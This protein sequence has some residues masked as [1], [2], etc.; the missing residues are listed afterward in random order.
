[1]VFRT[2]FL[3]GWPPEFFSDLWYKPSFFFRVETQKKKSG[4]Q[5]LKFYQG[6]KLN[7]PFLLVFHPK[8]QIRL[9]VCFFVKQEKLS[10]SLENTCSADFEFHSQSKIEKDSSVKGKRRFGKD[11]FFKPGCSKLYRNVFTTEKV[12]NISQNP[13]LQLPFCPPF[14]TPLFAPVLLNRVKMV[15]FEVLEQECSAQ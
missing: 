14:P 1:M 3:S 8:L 5:N 12:L 15:Q 2:C 10:F 4:S 7:F 6:L 13:R 9:L 11:F